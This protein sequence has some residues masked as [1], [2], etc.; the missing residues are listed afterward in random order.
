MFAL[1]PSLA[2]H[3]RDRTGHVDYFRLLRTP[4][5]QLVGLARQLPE[6]EWVSLYT[7][8]RQYQPGL[9]ERMA[10]AA[11]AID[12]EAQRRRFIRVLELAAQVAA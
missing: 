6:E 3:F 5:A 1:P 12:I 7:Q 10:A 4:D 11:A 9:L 8:L 2:Q